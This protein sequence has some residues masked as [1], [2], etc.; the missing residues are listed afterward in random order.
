MARVDARAD[1]HGG[2]SDPTCARSRVG[3]SA[4]AGAEG[5]DVHGS[6]EQDVETRASEVHG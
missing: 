1:V 6:S 3:W 5:I 2:R 4:R